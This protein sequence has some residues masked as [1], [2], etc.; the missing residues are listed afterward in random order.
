MDGFPYPPPAREVAPLQAPQP[1]CHRFGSHMRRTVTSSAEL[2]AVLAV[3][4]FLRMVVSHKR[5]PTW[6][7]TTPGRGIWWCST[8]ARAVRGRRRCSVARSP[9]TGAR[10]RYGE[11]RGR[12]FGV[13]SGAGARGAPARSAREEFVAAFGGGNPSIQCARAAAT[14][15]RIPRRAATECICSVLRG[16]RGVCARYSRTCAELHNLQP[17]LLLL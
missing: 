7:A 13:R 12:A 6:T 9:R 16:S 17:P 2:R 4:L 8:G 11:C 14:S 3:P 1:L 5:S 10:S 15:R